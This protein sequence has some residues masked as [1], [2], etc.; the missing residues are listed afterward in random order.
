MHTL[1]LLILGMGISG[2]SCAQEALARQRPVWAFDAKAKA[3]ASNDEEIRLLIDKG[4]K[5]FDEIEEL[6][7]HHFENGFEQ[8]ILSPGIPPGHPLVSRAKE[9]GWPI[10]TEIEYACTR[11]CCRKIAITGTNGKTTASLLTAHLLNK[12]GLR[13][14]CVGNI[15][16]PVTDLLNPLYAANSSSFDVLVLELSSFQ[17]EQMKTALFDAGL[18]LNID[19][20][21]LDRHGGLEA[22]AKAKLQLAHTLLPQ[23]PLYLHKTICNR[24]GNLIERENVLFTPFSLEEADQ[25]VK[26]QIAKSPFFFRHDRENLYAAATL[27]QSLGLPFERAIAAAEG[28]VKPRHRLEYVATRQGVAFY[29]DSKATNLHAVEAAVEAFKGPLVIIAGG[30]SKGAAFTSWRHVMAGKVKAICAI[31]QASMQIAEEVKGHIP[32]HLYGSLEEA[33]IA[34][35]ELARPAGCTVLLCPGCSSLDM[36]KS[37]EERGRI[38]REVIEKQIKTG[39]LTNLL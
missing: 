15:G 20:D 27:C 31:G 39:L 7:S 12:L 19:E 17:L 13:A 9:R 23:A 30:V 32:V 14:I 25:K 5:L 4:L 16:R 3:L 8:V 35:F 37:Y 29:D 34:A 11:L 18:I 21:H 22:Y 28:F 33:T 10:I 1:P 36:F 6:P 38:Y 26:E 2:R 24:F